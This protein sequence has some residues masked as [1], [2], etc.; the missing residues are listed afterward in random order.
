MNIHAVDAA[1]V[2]FYLLLVLAFGLWVGRDQRTSSDYFLGGRTLPWGVLL[3]SIV[4]TETSTVTFLSLPGIPAALNGNMTFLQ[5]A[6]GYIIGRL[7][8]IYVLLPIYFRRDTFTAYEVL[9]TR[10]G[11]LSRRLTSVLF[12]SIRYRSYP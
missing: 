3:L 1:I 5:I 7:L 2:V 12:L 8:I 6:I 10:F 11:T 4:A 9:E